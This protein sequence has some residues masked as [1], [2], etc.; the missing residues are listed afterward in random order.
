MKALSKVYL[1]Y[2]KEI[3]FYQDFYEKKIILE[4]VH[5][6]ICGIIIPFGEIK[7][8]HSLLKK[9][10]ASTFLEQYSKLFYL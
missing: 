3:F 4:T 1:D 8:S 2:M 7:R 10:L 6:Q 5:F 9:A